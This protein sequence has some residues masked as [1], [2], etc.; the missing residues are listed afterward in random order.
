[1]N[2]TLEDVFELIEAGNYDVALEMLRQ[3]SA[4]QLSEED[5]VDYVRCVAQCLGRTNRVAAAERVLRKG[6]RRYP[7][8]NR[9]LCELGILLSESD[10]EDEARGHFESI[11]ET[12]AD[13]PSV[14]YHYG[15][16]LEKLRYLEEAVKQYRRALELDAE[17]DWAYLRLAECLADLGDDPAA[18]ASF[19]EYLKRCPE[20][21]DAWTGFGIL[22][23]DAGRYE[24]ACH[25]YERGETLDCD[26]ENLYYNWFITLLR[27]GDVEA[28]AGTLSLLKKANPS[29]SRVL[30][31]EA[32]LAERHGDMEMLR[33][34]AWQAASRSLS[35]CSDHGE[36]G[37]SA[38][39]TIFRDQGWALDAEKLLEHALAKGLLPEDLLTAYNE[40]QQPHVSRGV[41]CALTVSAQPALDPTCGE[42]YLRCYEVEAVDVR[43]AQGLAI[44]MEQ[45]L[46]GEGC[47]VE[48]VDETQEIETFHPGVVW[49]DRVARPCRK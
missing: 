19:E 15:Y 45:R 9:L 12:A 40:L 5:R 24:E 14:A 39:M 34:R 26:R 27:R 43:A 4:E 25:C 10:R 36:E 18:S 11:L 46:G 23:S 49:I 1:M 29:G 33:L 20:D 22:H 31:A 17:H 47:R 3:M 6:L 8:D 30:Y 16:V 32:Y 28:A 2:P 7:D 48:G 42:R 13:D 41:W 37:F 44:A 35:E 21:G 38:T